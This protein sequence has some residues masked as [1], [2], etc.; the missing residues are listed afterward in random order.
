MRPFECFLLLDSFGQK[1]LVYC[2]LFGIV[3]VPD[4]SQTNSAN[5]DWRSNPL[6]SQNT[7][8]HCKALHCAAI[9]C[10]TLQ[11][12]KID[13]QPFGPLTATSKAQSNSS[14]IS[15][16]WFGHKATVESRANFGSTGKIRL[17]RGEIRNK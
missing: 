9:L 14:S 17:K 13:K 7:R 8:L 6:S 5:A 11:L 1:L 10:I 15:R 12:I 16:T 4:I 2:R 3:V